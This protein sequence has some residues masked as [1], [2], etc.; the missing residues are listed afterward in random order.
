MQANVWTDHVRTESDVGRITF[1]RAAAVAEVAWSPATVLSWP[2]FVARLAPQMKRYGK[3]N[4]PYSDAAF[5]I[6][7]SQRAGRGDRVAVE[8]S[9]Q[10]SAGDIRYTLNGGEPTAKSPIYSDVIEVAS[11]TTV[12]AA[13]FLDAQPLSATTTVTVNPGAIPAAPTTR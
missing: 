6:S 4:I 11:S 1:P 7:I 5:H 13:S 3:L 9:R 10:I 8:L 12:K 2:G